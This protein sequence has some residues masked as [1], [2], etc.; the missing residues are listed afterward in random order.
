MLLPEPLLPFVDYK[1]RLRRMG[2]RLIRYRM[3]P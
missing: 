3:Y 1:Y 2:A